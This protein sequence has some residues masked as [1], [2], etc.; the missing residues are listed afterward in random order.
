MVKN[1]PLD[2]DVGRKRMTYFLSD[3]DG[4]TW[5]EKG[6][7]REGEPCAYPDC[8]QAPDGTVYVVFDGDRFAKKEIHFRKFGVGAPALSGGAGAQPESQEEPSARFG[9][10]ADIHIDQTSQ[11]DHILI[12]IPEASYKNT[13]SVANLKANVRTN[14]NKNLFIFSTN[15]F[16]II[17]LPNYS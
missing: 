12:E 6:V 10:L 9:V 3:D 16:S 4:L 7:L 1:G 2:A 15:S 11:D 14:V 8:D 13:Y 17:N 5:R